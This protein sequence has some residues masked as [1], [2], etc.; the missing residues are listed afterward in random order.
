M[1]R[2]ILSYIGIALCIAILIYS[3]VDNISF[4]FFHLILVYAM[5]MFWHMSRPPRLNAPGNK[6]QPMDPKFAYTGAASMVMMLMCCYWA[7][8]NY[9]NPSTS[10]FMNIDHHVIAIDSIKINSPKNYRLAGNSKLAFFDHLDVDA[11]AYADI[12]D[13]DNDSIRIKLYGITTPLYRY[14]YDEDNRNINRVLLSQTFLPKISRDKEFTLVNNRNERLTVRIEECHTENLLKYDTDSTNYHIVVNGSEKSAAVSGVTKFI[15]TGLPLERLLPEVPEFDLEGIDLL[16]PTVFPTAGRNNIYE[17]LNGDYVLNFSRSAIKN[18]S[19][20]T[21]EYDGVSYNIK[22]L[23]TCVEQ[24]SIAYGQAIVFGYG[25]KRTT[26]VTFQKVKGKHGINMLFVDPCYRYLSSVSGGEGE[27]NTVY[28]TSSLATETQSADPLLPNNVIL[29]DFFRHRGNVHN[30]TPSY[31]S[32]VNGRSSET[33]NFNVHVKGANTTSHIKAGEEYPLT[34]T[35]VK[36]EEWCMS[37]KDFKSET[38]FTFFNICLFL[39]L[40]TISSVVVLLWGESKNM[41]INHYGILTFSNIELGSYMLILVFLTIRLF[42]LWRLSVFPPSSSISRYELYSIFR[43]E[44]QL[45]FLY[46]SVFGFFISVFIFKNFVIYHPYLFERIKKIIYS[47]FGFFIS[48]FIFKNFVIYRPDLFERIKKIISINWQK[49]IFFY[50]FFWIINCL[51]AVICFI[52]RS[53]RLCVLLPV[54]MYFLGDI[55]LTARFARSYMEDMT[56][57]DDSLIRRSNLK[58]FILTAINLLFWSGILFIND[59]GYGILFFSFG[60]IW[61]VLRLREIDMFA[62]GKAKWPLFLLYVSLVVLIVF[63]KYLFLLSVSNTFVFVLVCFGTG[64]LLTF[65]ILKSFFDKVLSLRNK[66]TYVGVAIWAALLIVLPTVLAK[67]VIPGTHLEQRI[68]V[69]MSAPAEQLVNLPDNVSENRFLQVSLNDYILANYYEEGDKIDLF[70]SKGEGYFHMVPHSRIGAMWGAQ[71]NDISLSRFV[72]AEHGP[73]LPVFLILSFFLLLCIGIQRPAHSRTAKGLYIQIPLLLFVQ[74]LV[75]WMAITR[76]FIFLGQDFPLISCNSKLTIIYTLILFLLLIAAAIYDSRY[77]LE[78]TIV[79]DDAIRKA[80]KSN[81]WIFALV[82]SLI[83][84]VFT[85]F[86]GAN[87]YKSEKYTMADALKKVNNVYNTVRIE[88]PDSVLTQSGMFIAKESKSNSKHTTSVSDEETINETALVSYT[89]NQLIDEWQNKDLGSKHWISNIHD[90]RYV[91]EEF[92]KEFGSYIDKVYSEID[93]TLLAKRLYHHYINRLAVH[94]DYS[95]IL[96]MH[97][98]RSTGKAILTVNSTYYDQTLPIRKKHS[99]IGNITEHIPHLA[100]QNSLNF[101][102]FSAQ[103][104]P[105]NWFADGQDVVMLRLKNDKHTLSVASLESEA[106]IMMDY[107]GNDGLTRIVRLFS[108]DNVLFNGKLQPRFASLMSM[109]SFFARNIQVNGQ[110]HFIYPMGD[111]LFWARNFSLRAQDEG[112]A[113]LQSKKEV[114]PLGDVPITLS[115]N[116]IREIYKVINDGRHE[117][118]VIVADGNGHI[119]ALVDTKIRANRVDPNDHYRLSDL[120]DSLYMTGGHGSGYERSVFGNL[121]LMNLVNGPGSSQKPLVYASITSGFDL[122]DCN[123]FKGWEELCLDTIR[124]Y[125]KDGKYYKMPQ[126]VGVKPYRIFSSLVND[127]GRSIEDVNPD[128]YIYKS[129]NFYNAMMAYIG[130]HNVNCFVPENLESFLTVAEEKDGK[131]LFYKSKPSL[132]MTKDEY[133]ESWPNMHRKNTQTFVRFN[134]KPDTLQNESLLQTRMYSLFGLPDSYD[135]STNTDLYP[136]FSDSNRRSYVNP[137]NSY[138]DAAAR[139]KK[140]EREFTE[141][142]IRQTAI[143]Q[144]SVWNVSP[145]DMAQMY[146]RLLPGQADMTFT[147]DPQVKKPKPRDLESDSNADFDKTIRSLFGSLEKVY[148]FESGTANAVYSAIK[149]LLFDQHGNQRYWV[150]G[151]TG[152]I[153]GGMSSSVIRNDDRLLATIITNQDLT[154]A[155]DIS[156]LRY[157]VV[158]SVLYNQSTP[159][160]DIRGNMLRKIICDPA[161]V[162]YM[163]S[164]KISKNKILNTRV[165]DL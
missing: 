20:T 10:I 103:R 85:C 42:L 109:N 68:R 84:I 35:K 162:E 126:F 12:A 88:V 62:E 134:M 51:I 73:W 159:F 71:T 118:A 144:R 7:L 112:K 83:A 132:Y 27:E 152:T 123:V 100:T 156:T 48:V 6:N 108:S 76:R 15:Q 54:I 135:P 19:I 98:N 56:E 151:K 129:S 29:F 18:G 165:G 1:K 140:S 66:W 13:F 99:W 89:L 163:N 125:M 30:V 148:S 36:G 59:G 102:G 39:L 55:I 49:D 34:P 147:L 106:P 61:T 117:R 121:A 4:G 81:M 149:D 25:E 95:N 53:T 141:I 120:V 72:I 69:H 111:T 105:G 110:R 79:Q 164:A 41:Y 75:I 161:F 146:C 17:L 137:E 45:Q 77:T 115:M 96:H 97:R 90:T 127:E 28:V 136:S 70:G 16:R 47:V 131:S 92:D 143:G 124:N 82:M 52:L 74:S 40:V 3:L 44:G 80:C 22:N 21:L 8:N 91:M 24:I 2:K 150:Y 9:I 145:F 33:M 93:S 153:G 23:Q 101:D 87:L 64:V 58:P 139:T 94:N 155:V 65:L 119:R 63:Y 128:A 130:S 104:F 113:R 11:N 31:L 138:L 38:P 133:E 67:V 14:D 158:Y 114:E 86:D 26:P 46:Y 107:S 37:I 160:N 142:A 5:I 57:S 50:A 60:L 157:Y 78:R 154:G 116:L 32:F 43:Q 122:A